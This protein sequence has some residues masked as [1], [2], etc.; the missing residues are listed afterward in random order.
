MA[1]KPPTIAS[2][3]RTATKS[4]KLYVENTCYILIEDD[5]ERIIE[6][7]TRLSLPRAWD[8]EQAEDTAE[9]SQEAID[10]VKDFAFELELMAGMT[11][12]LERNLR[13]I[14]WHISHPGEPDAA[15]SAGAVALIFDMQGDF[16]AFRI[17]RLMQLMKNTE[18]LS[19]QDWGTARELLNR[20]YRDYR[21]SVS[22]VV[23]RYL[24]ALLGA[25]EAEDAIAALQGYPQLMRKHT[26]ILEG[27]R[28]EVEEIRQTLAVQPD[29]YPLVSPPR[30]FGGDLLDS[31][32]WK[33][34]W[35]DVGTMSDS[36]R[37]HV[38]L[39]I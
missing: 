24:E 32:S 18:T 27:L 23:T 19:A 37:Q 33:H 2:L 34:F 13:K 11:K 15:A 6:Y 4:Q 12:Y 17:R 14:K 29:G 35:G 16:A 22:L 30:Y 39:G 28:S 3:V 1:T 8:P 20:A 9:W 38:G 36:L 10:N 21:S 25:S 7:F 5:K 31:T 26:E